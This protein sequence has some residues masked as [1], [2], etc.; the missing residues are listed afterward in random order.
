MKAKQAEQHGDSSRVSDWGLV[1]MTLGMKFEIFG[2][3]RM[4][5]LPPVRTERFSVSSEEWW[6]TSS[7]HRS[8]KLRETR[9]NRPEVLVLNTAPR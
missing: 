2:L 8:G 1:G 3:M 5:P 6:L 9:P 4:L 7:P